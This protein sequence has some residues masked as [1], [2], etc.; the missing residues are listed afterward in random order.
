MAY[1]LK[2]TTVV[3]ILRTQSVLIGN[4]VGYTFL[5]IIKEYNTKY[6]TTI[7]LGCL[8]GCLVL[9][10]ILALLMKS[11]NYTAIKCGDIGK[12][13]CNNIYIE[14]NSFIKAKEREV[15]LMLM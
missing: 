12:L 8:S 13:L 3:G 1:P 6:V 5:L 2:E 14:S 11:I 15:R 9:G 10:I 7:M 4:L